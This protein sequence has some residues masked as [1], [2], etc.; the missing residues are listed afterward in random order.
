M[1]IKDFKKSN[2]KS[3][4]YIEDNELKI[5]YSDF[6]TITNEETIE[7]YYPCK[8]KLDLINDILISKSLVVDDRFECDLTQKDINKLIKIL[9]NIKDIRSI[10]KDILN[11]VNEEINIICN[12]VFKNIYESIVNVSNMKEMFELMDDIKEQE[13]LLFENALI[14]RQIDLEREEFESEVL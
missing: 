5:Y 13:E 8:D 11:H 14:Q 1:N 7:V 12:I 6:K 2:I 9:T 4:C 10:K 3:V